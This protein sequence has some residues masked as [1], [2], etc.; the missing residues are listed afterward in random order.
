MDLMLNRFV[1]SFTCHPPV[2]AFF[3]AKG[4]ATMALRVVDP[5]AH[6]VSEP[7]ISGQ[8]PSARGG[9]TVS[10]TRFWN[11]IMAT[12]LSLRGD[13]WFCGNRVRRRAR[14]A[15]ACRSTRKGMHLAVSPVSLRAQR[16]LRQCLLSWPQST[17]GHVSITRPAFRIR[18]PAGAFGGP[19]APR[20][21]PQM[22]PFCGV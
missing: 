8:A 17:T 13:S 18:R 9:H 7:E 22:S 6:T 12:V 2:L 21:G 19:P 3:Q 5:A 1:R 14:V 4:A 16:L 10:H 20:G 11:R 15:G